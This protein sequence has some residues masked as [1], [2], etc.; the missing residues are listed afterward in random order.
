TR[1]CLGSA[2]SSAKKLLS[3]LAAARRPGS[4]SKYTATCRCDPSRKQA[5]VSSADHGGE[6]RRSV[7]RRV[8]CPRRL[9]PRSRAAHAGARLRSAEVRVLR[10]DSFSSRLRSLVLHYAARE[11]LLVEKFRKLGAVTASAAPRHQSVVASPHP[12]RHFASEDGRN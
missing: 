1:F 8:S 10:P 6:K 7:S 4:S 12:R 2:A 5:S 11:V 9:A 3:S